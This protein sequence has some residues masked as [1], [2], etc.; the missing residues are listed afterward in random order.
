MSEQII[1]GDTPTFEFTITDDAGA[2]VDLTNTTSIKFIA[3]SSLD[4]A[5]GSAIFD[6]TCAVVSPATDGICRVTLD[7]GDSAV[8][9]IFFAELELRF[10]DGSIFTATQFLLDILDEVRSTA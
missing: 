5:D 9:G 8:A 2:A 1:K 4:L 3:K 6:K 10:S 7:A